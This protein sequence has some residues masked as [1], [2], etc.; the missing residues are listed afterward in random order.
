MKRKVNDLER[1]LVLNRRS[2]LARI[3]YDTIKYRLDA[4]RRRHARLKCNLKKDVISDEI[5]VLLE[6]R[7]RRE[8]EYSK[9]HNDDEGELYM[10][11][12]P[13]LEMVVP[14]LDGFSL[15]NY[16]LTN[17]RN[18]C[19]GEANTETNVKILNA[20]YMLFKEKME[21]IESEM[22]TMNVS[23]KPK[24]SRRRRSGKQKK[25]RLSDD[26]PEL[27]LPMI[28]PWIESKEVI[29]SLR[30][31][32]RYWMKAIQLEPLD[33]VLCHTTASRHGRYEGLR[34]MS[35]QNLLRVLVRIV[36]CSNFIFHT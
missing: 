23:K 25:G 19:W 34:S 29:S 9:Y 18:F 30:L 11:D 28:T 12:H 14:F 4:Y 22:A 32:N 35:R 3:R 33:I 20:R 16:A 6:E 36:L 24:F 21:R 1:R 8:E 10:F 17:S 2:E 15:Q 7:D 5:R 27:L 13:A 31:V 26:L